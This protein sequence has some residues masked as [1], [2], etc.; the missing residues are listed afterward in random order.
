MISLNIV[1]RVTL[2]K[3]LALYPESIRKRVSDEMKR[4]VI[5]FANNAKTPNLSGLF[6]NVKTGGLR[7]SVYW[8]VESSPVNIVGYVG[9]NKWYGTLWHEGF[10]RNFKSGSKTFA[11]RPYLKDIIDKRKEEVIT[12][13]NNAIRGAYGS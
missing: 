2:E 5:N 9:T 4:I 3:N 13:L 12:R 1:G 10:T 11:P 7:N 6:L 8:K